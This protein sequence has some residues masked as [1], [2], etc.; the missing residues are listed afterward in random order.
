MP[1]IRSLKPDFTQNDKL[2][3]LPAETH[4]LAAG[5]ICYADDEGYF[6][7]NPKLV[8]AA[9]FPLRELSGNIPEALRSLAGIG[10]I[11]LR[12]GSDGREYGR[13]V[14]FAEHQRV[15]HKVKS[16]IK[17]FWMDSGNIPEDSGG[18]PA[19]LRPELNRGGIELNRIEGEGKPASP[20][21]SFEDLKPSEAALMYL[22]HED[23]CIPVTKWEISDTAAAL[24]AIQRQEHLDT[25]PALEW[26]LDRARKY[27][28]SGKKVAPGWARKAGYNEAGPKKPPPM[29]N[30]LDL[31]RQQ[32]MEAGK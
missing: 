10:Y 13:I 7:A 26:L 23:I 21:L 3:A 20:P 16:S 30:A 31:K 24:E 29:V 28:A 4:L 25:L 15:S 12:A 22:E 27:K 5:L 11:E 32:A 2:S 18:T 8:Q 1:R 19:V 9:I 14:H 6:R 17:P